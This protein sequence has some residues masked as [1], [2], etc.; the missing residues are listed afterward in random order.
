MSLIANIPGSVP[1]KL[2]NINFANYR[3][4][5]FMNARECGAQLIFARQG[6]IK[7]MI[8]VVLTFNE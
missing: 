2:L 1:D 3:V 8:D 6:N 5:L 7:S 4:N